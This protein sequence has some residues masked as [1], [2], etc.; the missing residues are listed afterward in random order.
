MF[1]YYAIEDKWPRKPTN[2]SHGCSHARTFQTNSSTA[3]LFCS[4]FLSSHLHSV[5]LRLLTT[6]TV[7]RA[8]ALSLRV[9]K[10]RGIWWL[11][12]VSQSFSSLPSHPSNAQRRFRLSLP[13][14][15]FHRATEAPKVQ[16]CD[17]SNK[18]FLAPCRV[19]LTFIC[20]AFLPNCNYLS[21][22]DVAWYFTG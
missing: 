11:N 9:T 3:C 5:I 14:G 13:F 15:H 22:V 2:C 1:M 4:V 7:M 21:S 12:A 20:P 18:T 8:K 17:A 16:E 10:A 19:I 6:E